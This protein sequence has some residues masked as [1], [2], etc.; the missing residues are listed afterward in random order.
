MQYR[1]V[2]GSGLQVSTLALGSWLTYGGS[3]VAAGDAVDMVRRAYELGINYFDTADVYQGGEAERLLA[4]ALDGIPRSSVVLATKAF[5]PVGRG[6]NDRGLSRK[7]LIEG[8]EASLKRLNTD[9]VDMFFCHRFDAR[10]PLEETLRTLDDLVRAGKILYVGIS[11]WTAA[12]IERAVGLQAVHG[13]EPIRVSQ[14]RYNM[15]NRDIEREIIPTCERAGIGQVVWSPL[16]EGFLTGKYREGQAPPSE[17][18]AADKRL[19]AS[20]REYMTPANYETVRRLGNVAE[21]AGMPLPRMALAWTL[22]QP[23]V[24]AAIIGASRLSQL[25]ENVAAADVVLSAD[26]MEA[27]EQVL[28]AQMGDTDG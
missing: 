7:H 28:G 3:A 6:P 19:G 11:E 8:V 25:D 23:N 27:I 16:A 10:V 22:R 15:L 5:W 12:Q 18:R 14:P 13:W 1:Y 24:A 20:A 4:K 9:Y 17:S 21:E 2:G 26:L